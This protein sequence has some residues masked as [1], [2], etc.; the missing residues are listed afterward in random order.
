MM[1]K[2]EHLNE[3]LRLCQEMYERMKRDGIWPWSDSLE[4]EDVVESDNNSDIA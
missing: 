3:H 4:S 1:N 2:D